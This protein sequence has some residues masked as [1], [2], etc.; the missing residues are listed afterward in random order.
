MPANDSVCGHSIF[1]GVFDVVTKKRYLRNSS[2][3]EF[4]LDYLQRNNMTQK[5]FVIGL[6]E[7]EIERDFNQRAD[8]SEASTDSE[9]VA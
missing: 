1:C 2:V 6:I 5:Q 9:R 8:I 3:C 7:N 4:I